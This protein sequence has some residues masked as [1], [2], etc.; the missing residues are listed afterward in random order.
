MSRRLARIAA[1]AVLLG[2]ATASAERGSSDWMRERLIFEWLVGTGGWRTSV[3][4]DTQSPGFDTL[5]GGSEVTL[6]LEAV[7]P[8][9]FFA[10]GRF[11]A[12]SRLGGLMYEGSGGIGVQFHVAERVR[13]RVAASAGQ[14]HVE[15][16]SLLEGTMVGGYLASSFALFNAGRYL[17]GVLAARLDIDG[18][19]GPKDLPA[20]SLALAIG[21]GLYY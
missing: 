4:G 15:R 8:V 9:G 11:I 17:S 13:L 19:L 7:G 3:G 6:G 12:G 10:N 1:L 20:S 16:P 2:A 14:L 5:A 18:I 21:I